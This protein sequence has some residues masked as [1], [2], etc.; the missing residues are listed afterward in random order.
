MLTN[1][2]HKVL[3]LHHG[4]G[5][6]VLLLAALDAMTVSGAYATASQ[7][8]WVLL[9]F[10]AVLGL[11]LMGL[12]QA[13]SWMLP[14][15][16]AASAGSSDDE[17]AS[18]LK[19]VLTLLLAGTFLFVG[20]Q[21]LCAATIPAWLL[22]SVPVFSAAFLA[23]PGLSLLAA[24]LMAFVALMLAGMGLLGT[25]PFG[26]TAS[27]VFLSSTGA[28]TAMVGWAVM[29]VIALWTY[30]ARQVASLMQ[31]SSTQV[32][33]LQSMATTDALTGLINRR[34]FNLQLQGEWSRAR[35]HHSALCLALFDV[36][37]FK[38][39]NDTYGHPVGDRILKELAALVAHNLRDSDI[40][41]RYGGEEFAL[42]L[43]ETRQMEAAELMERVRVLI[44]RHVFCLP[45]NP[46]TVTVSIGVAQ[47]DAKAHTRPE[48][49]VG[50][51]DAALYEAKHQGKNR[52]IYGVLPVPKVSYRSSRNTVAPQPFHPSY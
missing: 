5:A 49:L 8:A 46:Q 19:P 27:S 43:T 4:L 26:V 40:P 47:F 38:K 44:E 37:N 50:Q 25:T 48:D 30:M 9:A 3:R 22:M 23:R 14:K 18:A 36:D 42:I 6:A 1:H 35:R 16:T 32:T 33:R 45:D 11:G 15:M 34:L 7:W 29:P 52:V 24:G 31:S 41:A 28:P 20:L 2:C 13:V 39:I 51:A 12:T 21:A 10:R 17:A